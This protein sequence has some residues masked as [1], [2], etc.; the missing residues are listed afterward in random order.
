MN[1]IFMLIF[2]GIAITVVFKIG[3]LIYLLFKLGFNFEVI[4]FLVFL[5]V[6][7]TF[8]T[9][10]LI[11]TD[12]STAGLVISS[13]IGGAVLPYL[14]DITKIS[15]NLITGKRNQRAYLKT[16]THGATTVVGMGIVET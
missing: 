12:N 7:A 10:I 2:T 5:G 4:K 9:L 14:F 6:M 13:L 3:H 11:G 16:T 8:V 15:R 1:I